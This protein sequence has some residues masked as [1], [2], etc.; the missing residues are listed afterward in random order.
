MVSVHNRTFI[1]FLFL[2]FLRKKEKNR[3][4]KKNYITSN[5]L[6]AF[7]KCIANG[8]KSSGC[9]QKETDYL[10]NDCFNPSLLL[11]IFEE[12]YGSEM[13]GNNF[14]ISKQFG[15]L[16]Y[17]FKVIDNKV[18]Y[19]SFKKSLWHSLLKALLQE[20]AWFDRPLW[21]EGI[22]GWFPVILSPWLLTISK[23]QKLNEPQFPLLWNEVIF[24]LLYGSHTRTE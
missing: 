1:F 21:S 16:Q 10:L 17:Y 24:Y 19:D 14:F 20:E 8:E 13:A 15:Q 18:W 4:K 9:G 6:P 23:V 22:Q 11:I 2:L 7:I 12:V 5:C 3:I